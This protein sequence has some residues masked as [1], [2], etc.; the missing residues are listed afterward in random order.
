MGYFKSIM[1]SSLMT[2]WV[3]SAECSCVMCCVMRV[4][5][6]RQQ[7]LCWKKFSTHNAKFVILAV[8][9]DSYR[10]KESCSHVQ[11]ECTYIL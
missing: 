7:L 11:L 1:Y 6:L 5:E 8:L 3:F 4:H 9:Q 10:S 2:S